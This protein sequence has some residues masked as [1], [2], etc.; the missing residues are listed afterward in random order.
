MGLGGIKDQVRPGTLPQGYSL[1][2]M[3]SSRLK[4]RRDV[5]K[6]QCPSGRSHPDCE[7]RKGFMEEAAFETDFSH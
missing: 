1:R 4:A 6:K 5:V 3:E 2:E 7:A